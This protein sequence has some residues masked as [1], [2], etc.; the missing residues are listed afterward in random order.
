M[1]AGAP[2]QWLVDSAALRQ[3]IRNTLPTWTP[4]SKSNPLLGIETALR[5][6]RRAGQRIS[7]Y[8][9]GDDFAGESMQ[10]AAESIA[11][12]NA[13]DGKRPRA[14]IHAFGFPEGA[15]MRA[16]T[17]IQFSAL[18]RVVTG[19]N[20]GTFVGITSEKPCRSFTEV[21]GMR[22]CLGR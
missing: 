1:F 12:L 7:I 21:L 6:Y 10:R 2:G 20:D 14:R 16:Y 8:V 17:T 4:F 11:K 22:Q 5:Y 3:K 18:M 15:G 9:I 19:Q 13:A